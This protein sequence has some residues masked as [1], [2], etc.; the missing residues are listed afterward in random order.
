MLR[1]FAFVNALINIWSCGCGAWHHRA[2]VPSRVGEGAAFPEQGAAWTLLLRALIPSLP[3][4]HF[5]FRNRKHASK[6][7]I[8][9][10][11]APNSQ[12]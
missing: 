6:Y 12:D 11:K 3:A 10:F 2:T 8:M 1:L 5:A 4:Q 9:G 7:V